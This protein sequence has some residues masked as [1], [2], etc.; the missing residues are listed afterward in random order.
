MHESLSE[1]FPT[2]FTWNPSLKLWTKRVRNVLMY[3][4]MVNIHPANV[5]IFHLRLLL[6][7]RKNAKSFKKLQTIDGVNMGPTEQLNCFEFMPE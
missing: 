2:K 6:K 3:G 1:D 5:E 4:R 7:N